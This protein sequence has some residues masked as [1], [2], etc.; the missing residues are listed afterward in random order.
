MCLPI[1]VTFFLLHRIEEAFDV[2]IE[3]IY[4]LPEKMK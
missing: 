4:F 3:S 1:V 2:L